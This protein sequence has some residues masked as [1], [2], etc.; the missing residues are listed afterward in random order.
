MGNLRNY[1]ELNNLWPEPG[2]IT[3]FNKNNEALSPTR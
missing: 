1:V 2:P 3:L